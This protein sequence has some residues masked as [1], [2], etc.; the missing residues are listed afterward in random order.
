MEMKST[1][2]MG[3][4][5][6][7]I[8]LYSFDRENADK[9]LPCACR[10]LNE[11]FRNEVIVA[12]YED[13]IEKV[14]DAF[15]GDIRIGIRVRNR[16]E[17]GKRFFDLYPN[18]FT[19]RSLR[20][21]KFGNQIRTELAK[22]MEPPFWGDYF[23]Y[24]Q[25]D[26]SGVIITDWMLLD[27]DVFREGSKLGVSPVET[28]KPNIDNTTFFNA[29]DIH[30]FDPSIVVAS[31]LKFNSTRNYERDKVRFSAYHPPRDAKLPLD[32]NAKLPLDLNAKLPLD[33]N[34]KLPLDLIAGL[35]KLRFGL[36]RWDRPPWDSVLKGA[37]RFAL[38]WHN[39]AMDVGW[40]MIELYGL[41]PIA[42]GPR[43]QCRGF[44]FM[45]YRTDD[46]VLEI[47]P[48][49]IVFKRGSSILR[50]YRWPDNS[51]GAI[52]AWNIQ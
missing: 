18:Q 31:T 15:A 41:H 35:N 52:L 1:N 23:M 42:P 22:I 5:M 13:D 14:T 9:S 32:L 26:E 25:T 49:A 39:I 19:I 6:R 44:A 16:R 28:N 2:S 8:R 12:P 24:G 46:V 43:V 34:A 21:D 40:T 51:G 17:D 33:L 7:R 45:Y 36:S 29:Y 10:I 30:L 4:K 50:Y 20:F 27:L 47:T 11:F 37:V 38:E 48:E 3:V